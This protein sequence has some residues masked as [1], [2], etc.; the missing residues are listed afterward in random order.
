[1]KIGIII[2]IKSLRLE[3]IRGKMHCTHIG[4]ENCF[5]KCPTMCRF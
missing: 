4:I 1:M 5:P 3:I 2:E